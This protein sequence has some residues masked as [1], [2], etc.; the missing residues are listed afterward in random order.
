MPTQM[1]AASNYVMYVPNAAINQKANEEHTYTMTGGIMF[2]G[3]PN[4]I[5]YNGE[6]G[7]ADE[8]Q[9]KFLS[10][11]RYAILGTKDY[12]PGKTY[13]G[14]QNDEISVDYRQSVTINNS[15]FNALDPKEATATRVNFF[16]NRDARIANTSIEFAKADDSNNALFKE[17]KSNGDGTYT[18]VTDDKVS[19]V[20]DTDVDFKLTVTDVWGAV[21]EYTFTVTVKA[22][23]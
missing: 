8:F 11:I 13:E 9:I 16:E 4:L 12:I 15:Y 17:I 5:S 1:P 3:L 14:M 22:N 18:L 19:M 10:P 2:Y 23:M 6:G 21:T 20:K 7:F